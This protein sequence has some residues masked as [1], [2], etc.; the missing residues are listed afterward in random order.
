MG[1]SVKK[2]TLQNK[3]TNDICTKFVLLSHWI[4][5]YFAITDLFGKYIL[6]YVDVGLKTIKRIHL[7]I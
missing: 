6:T 4:T 1:K 2:V 3:R 7:C 5:P